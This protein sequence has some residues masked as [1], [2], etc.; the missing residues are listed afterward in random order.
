MPLWRSSSS[1]RLSKAFNHHF[2][3]LKTER[4]SVIKKTFS[5]I[6]SPGYKILALCQTNLPAFWATKRN[7]GSPCQKV[8]TWQQSRNNWPTYKTM[9][10]HNPVTMTLHCNLIIYIVLC[11][12]ISQPCNN[13]EPPDRMPTSR[14][15]FLSWLCLRLWIQHWRTLWY[16]SS[17]SIDAPLVVSTN[18]SNRDSSFSLISSVRGPLS[19]KFSSTA[20][21]SSL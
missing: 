17:I 11:Y 7:P 18:K 19:L 2:Q 3:F 10:P 9:R 6:S 4:Q 5:H 14:S 15:C 20:L 12:N 1:R 13:Q 21:S 8:L 16:L